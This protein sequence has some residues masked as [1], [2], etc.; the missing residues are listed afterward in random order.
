M[1]ALDV[2]GTWYNQHG[3]EL[4]LEVDSR[5]R[6]TGEFRSH[7]GLAR[8]GDPCAV[9]GYATKDLIAF[10]VDFGRFDSLTAWT[11]H[12]VLEAGEQRIRACWHMSVEVPAKHPELE[13]W[14]GT[15]TGE[16]EFRR[17]PFGVR[18]WTGGSQPLPEWP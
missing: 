9:T 15:W 14:K 17:A 16:D 11:G 4:R 10:V 13:L 18:E 2:S 7:S 8:A 6:L 3:S 12:C 5:G 1:T